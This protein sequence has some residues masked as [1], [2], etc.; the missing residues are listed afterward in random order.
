[1]IN[2]IIY[3]HGSYYKRNFGDYLLLKRLMLEIGPEFACLPFSSKEVLQEFHGKTKLFSIKDVFKVKACVFGGGGYLGEPPINKVKWSIGFLKRHFLPFMFCRFFNIPVYIIGAGFGPIT[4]SWLKPF[5]RFMLN[6][7]KVVWLRDKESIDLAKNISDNPNIQLVTD[8]AQDKSFL[9]EESKCSTV[10][11]PDSKYIA[12][13]VGLE[14][15]SGNR[16]LLENIFEKFLEYGY[17]FVF[18]TDSPGHDKNLIRGNVEFSCFRDKHKDAIL[19]I[20]Y[21]DASDVICIIKN[22]SGVITG[23]LHV[24]IVACSLSKNVLSFPL[25]HKTIRYYRDIQNEN[26]CVEEHSSNHACTDFINSFYDSVLSENVFELPENV[27]LRH[28]KAI[29]KVKD[30]ILD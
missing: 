10:N 16:A 8:L 2:K 30:I 29:Q 17:K 9:I 24:G 22:A 25:H 15:N 6:K 11:L 28:E 23:K 19:D 20:S 12:I 4:C 3:I 26:V 7:S 13:H 1:M 27:I 21:K 18:F 14:V 5:V